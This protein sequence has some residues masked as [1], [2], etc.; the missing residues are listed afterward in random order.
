[1]DPVAL[2]TAIVGLITAYFGARAARAQSQAAEQGS[3]ITSDQ[4]NMPQLEALIS[5]IETYPPTIRS[6][7]MLRVHPQHRDAAAQLT[8]ELEHA[9]LTDTDLAD[10]A[11]IT[12][13]TL[14]MRN[15]PISITDSGAVALENVKMR[16]RY[17]A[18]RDLHVNPPPE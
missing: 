7:E 5:Q 10:L 9:F 12:Y 2:A 1:M 8:A 14:S 4:V 11:R 13:Q 16:G 18:G 17:V 15:N 3:S 6:L